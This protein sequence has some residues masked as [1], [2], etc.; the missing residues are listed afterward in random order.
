[1][2]ATR[3]ADVQKFQ[4]IPNVGSAMERDFK[5][6]GLRSPQELAGKD[7]LKLYE[8]MCTLTN[9][10]QDVLDTYLAVIDFMNGAKVR[11]WWDYTEE[12]KRIH[13]DI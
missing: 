6:L 3:A 7:A 2:K 5:E 13:P 11:P 12:R 9:T 1:M 10:R 4:D 8:K